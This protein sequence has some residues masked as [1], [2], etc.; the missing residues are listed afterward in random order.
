MADAPVADAEREAETP[1]VEEP[2]SEDEACIEP[3]PFKKHHGFAAS[4]KG[5]RVY[6][7]I[8]K[9]MVKKNMRK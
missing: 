5:K 1:P 4:G 7:D 9:A 3:G 2:L 6:L 8:L